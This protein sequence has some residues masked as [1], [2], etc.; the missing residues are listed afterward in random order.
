MAERPSA[1]ICTKAPFQRSVQIEPTEAE[2][3]SALLEAAAPALPAAAPSDSTAAPTLAAALLAATMPHPAQAM[4]QGGSVVSGSATITQTGNLTLGAG[5]Q[6]G[7]VT[8]STS[9]YANVV[10]S[11]RNEV[12]TLGQG[13]SS[14]LAS[15]AVSPAAAVRPAAAKAAP[16]AAASTP[17]KKAAAKVGRHAAAATAAAAK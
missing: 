5:V 15:T 16:V 3:A 2:Q 1:P 6:T 14:A 7:A 9:Y 10:P 4:P 17:D 11:V 13:L 8:D 12:Q